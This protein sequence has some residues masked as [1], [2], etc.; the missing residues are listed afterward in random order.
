ML[1][2]V[3]ELSLIHIS[4]TRAKFED[5][6]SDLVESTLEPVRKALKDAKMTKKDIDKVILV[7]GSTRVPT[8]SYT[9]LENY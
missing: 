5:V 7:G 9:H 3:L 1:L 2:R 8:V 4:L 6:I